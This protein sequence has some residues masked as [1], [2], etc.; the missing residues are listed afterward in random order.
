MTVGDAAGGTGQARVPA[1]P[2]GAAFMGTTILRDR[3]HCPQLALNVGSLHRRSL[4]GVG[5]RPDSSR[6]SRKRRS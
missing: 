6:T 4:S 1:V 2:C 5:G 3:T